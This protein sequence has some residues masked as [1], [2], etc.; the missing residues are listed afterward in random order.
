MVCKNMKKKENPSP[1]F[2][3]FGGWILYYQWQPTQKKWKSWSQPRPKV[4]CVEVGGQCKE[5]WK[6]KKT[7]LICGNFPFAETW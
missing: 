7:C 2:K 5:G 1:L 6:G 4:Y 3:S